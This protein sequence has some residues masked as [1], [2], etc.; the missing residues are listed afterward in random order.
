MT[1]HAKL[2]IARYEIIAGLESFGAKPGERLTAAQGLENFKKYFRE[3]IA[4]A[5][6]ARVNHAVYPVAEGLSKEISDALTEIL[7]KQKQSADKTAAQSLTVYARYYIGKLIFGVND[8]VKRSLDDANAS[9]DDEVLAKF[10]LPI[11]ERDTLHFVRKSGAFENITSNLEEISTSAETLG[12]ALVNSY[13]RLQNLNGEKPGS[14]FA[15]QINF[16][17][18]AEM[19]ALSGYPGADSKISE[20]LAVPMTTGHEGAL[21]DIHHYEPE[22]IVF[23]TPDK[24]FVKDQYRLD[25]KSEGNAHVSVRGQ[26]E[27]LRGYAHMMHFFKPWEPS[28]FDLGLGALRIDEAPSVKA[29]D[30]AD[31]FLLSLGLASTIL[32]NIPLKMLGLITDKGAFIESTASTDSSKLPVTGAV[33]GDYEINKMSHV[34]LTRDMALAIEA[35]SEFLAESGDLEN[36]TDPTIIDALKATPAESLRGQLKKLL[37][38][39]ILFSTGKLMAVDGG[40][41][42]C[43]DGDSATASKKP[44]QLEDQ[45]LME[46][47]LLTAG[48]VLNSNFILARAADNFFFL[49]GHLWSP[50][51]GFYRESEVV[52]QATIQASGQA[53]GQALGQDSV[54]LKNV[55]LALGNIVKLAEVLPREMTQSDNLKE[56]QYQLQRLKDLWISR[57][58]NGELLGDSPVNQ[59]M[60]YSL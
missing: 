13:Y 26:M 46:R 32:K 29:F 56:S 4:G 41:A 6:R 59:V 16:K 58:F 19:L 42:P 45:L 27:L 15:V 12:A 34:I 48:T 47:A 17:S 20:S 60:E 38:G 57:F 2:A 3:K 14:L 18:I 22:K 54:S 40:F 11:L 36:S 7:D 52:G 21:L 49:N 23:A 51:L 39:L 5:T 33:V 1:G 53:S 24:V 31:Y 55:A 37:S 10:P 9:Q 8:L 43:Y 50:E 28:I 35:V 44:R 25:R 30:R